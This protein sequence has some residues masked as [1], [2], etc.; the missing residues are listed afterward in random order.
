MRD[1]VILSS[2]RAYEFPPDRIRLT[3]LSTPPVM[4]R[5][6][7]A[8]AFQSAVVG[9]PMATFGDVLATYPPGVVFDNGMLVTENGL[10][11]PVRFL[12]FESRRVVIDMAGQSSLTEAVFDRIRLI[13]SDIQAPDGQPAL[14]AY[15]AILEYSEITAA[16]DFDL[17]D[18]LRPGLLDLF[19]R[20]MDTSRQ[21]FP[22][23]ILPTIQLQKH[24][25][26]AEYPGPILSAQSAAIQ[27][28]LRAGHRAD[29]HTYFSAAPLD[30]EAHLAYLT[31]LEAVAT[32]RPASKRQ[33][34][35]TASGARSK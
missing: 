19:E 13:L 15:D 28:A 35:T 29:S 20:V 1:V 25:L 6:R 12:H 18:L 26:E 24:P 27:I 5:I 21:T 33:A 32:N 9:T 10:V 3:M 22:T 14:G 7:Q 31:E 23:A 2:R 17:T 8:F 4:E 16:F 30:S 11:A 34:V